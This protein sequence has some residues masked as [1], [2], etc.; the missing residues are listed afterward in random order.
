MKYFATIKYC[1]LI[2][3]L[4]LG[5]GCD[6]KSEAPDPPL[7]AG[8]L[9]IRL[10]DSL[11]KDDFILSS[12]QGRKLEL[13]IGDN[14]FLAQLE[15]I[16]E[17]NFYVLQANGALRKGELDK[18]GVFIQNGLRKYPENDRLRGMQQGITELKNITNLLEVASRTRRSGDLRNVLGRIR[19][20]MM[21]N[22]YAAGLEPAVKAYERIG[23]ALAQHEYE[24]TLFGFEADMADAEFA[25]GGIAGLI[26]GQIKYERDFN[27]TK[28]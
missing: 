8:E 21:L 18:A 2:L 10:F 19:E 1:L 3:M 28:K 6:E 16:Q 12:E 23:D 11:K 14:S 22:N 24:R 9:L 15:R 17:A 20:F 7:A 26:A 25:S 4:I 13:A 5:G 27:K